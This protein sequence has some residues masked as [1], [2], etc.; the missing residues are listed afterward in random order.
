MASSAVGTLGA[1]EQRRRRA[2]AGLQTVRRT[3]LD[4]GTVASIGF[5]LFG[6]GVS[7]TLPLLFSVAGN[8]GGHAD[9]RSMRRQYV[10]QL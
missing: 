2:A 10:Q 5:V 3:L 7:Y 1:I 4:R 8:L 9:V 6:A